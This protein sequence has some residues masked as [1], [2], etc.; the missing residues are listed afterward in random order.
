[1]RFALLLAAG[2][3]RI[4]FE[5]PA[6]GDAD[7]QLVQSAGS[8]AAGAGAEPVTIAAS[9]SGHLLVVAVQRQLGVPITSVTDNA[10]AGGN[11]YVAAPVTSSSFTTLELWF[12]VDSQPG[13]TAVSA[14]GG[15]VQSTVVWEFSGIDTIDPL[16]T[17]SQVSD[18]T[19]SITPVG[20]MIETTVPGELVVTAILMQAN[21]LGLQSG[22]AFTNDRDT[23]HNGFAH[24]T[25]NATPPG[26]HQ[27]RWLQDVPAVYHSSAIAFFPAR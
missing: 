7:W 9:G 21:S 20:P 10:S 24:L 5:P 4:A 13:A 1:V 23:N 25:S 27:A 11:V 22:S 16:H 3:G 17:T 18:Q 15:T 19:G 8:P 2:C 12:A 6:V 26:T 14:N